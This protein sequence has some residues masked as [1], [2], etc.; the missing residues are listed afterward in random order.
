MAVL[1]PGKPSRSADALIRQFAYSYS[2]L[3]H[4]RTLSGPLR[5]FLL[6][7]LFGLEAVGLDLLGGGLAPGSFCRFA[8]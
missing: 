2:I 5:A 6:R 4:P 7:A 3:G 1:P 8:E